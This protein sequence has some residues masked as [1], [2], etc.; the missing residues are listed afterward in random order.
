MKALEKEH[1]W[2]EKVRN[3]MTFKYLSDEE[4]DKMVETGSVLQYERNEPIV[5]EGELDH[6]FF[7]VLSGTVSVSV[8]E[9]GGK[10]VFICAL[11]EGEV[12]GEAGFFLKIHR[13][14]SVIARDRAVVFRLERTELAS[15]IRTFPSAGNKILL[16]TIYGL[17][18]KLRAANQELA[19][20]RK[21]DLE[22]ADIDDLVGD[23]LNEMEG[24]VR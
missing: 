17:L 13:T 11:G 9:A 5:R 22:Q 15:F 8:S 23:L 2:R 21:A 24:A 20:E 19:Y 1:A 6:H 3:I 14:A 10:D 18:K 12:F 7:G 16:I 4:L